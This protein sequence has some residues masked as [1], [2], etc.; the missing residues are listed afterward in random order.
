MFIT[1]HPVLLFYE[2][3]FEVEV[4][5]KLLLTVNQPVYLGVE[6][7]SGAHDQIFVLCLTIAGFLMW[8]ALS[9]ERMCL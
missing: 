2:L 9:D 1:L 7:P 3:P 6:L 8:G 5:V 4:E